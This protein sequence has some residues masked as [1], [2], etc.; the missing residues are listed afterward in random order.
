MAQLKIVVQ[1]SVSKKD[2][3]K[4][5]FTNQIV[6]IQL[7]IFSM[8]STKQIE[9]KSNQFLLK[10]PLENLKKSI[11]KNQLYNQEPV[12]RK[13]ASLLFYWRT[14]LIILEY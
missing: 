6:M 8:N 5:H 14:L 11:F 9:E 4:A 2:I 3:G 1:A 7:P 13:Y 12:A 10:V